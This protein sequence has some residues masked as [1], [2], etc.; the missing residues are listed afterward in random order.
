MYVIL[1]CYLVLNKMLVSNIL[2]WKN[3]IELIIVFMIRSILK[4]F[5][6]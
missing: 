6:K 3:I 4:K 1:I 2:M 5:T